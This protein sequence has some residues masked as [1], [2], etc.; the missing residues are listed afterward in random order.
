M[1]IPVLLAF[2]DWTLLFLRLVV[3]LIFLAHGWPKLKDLKATQ[4]NF[5]MMGFKPGWLWGT[6][7]A[8]LEGIGS[9]LLILGLLTQAFGLLF[10]VEMV[11]AAVWKKNRGMGLVNGYELDLLL[12]VAGLVLATMGGGRWALGF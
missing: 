3:G 5:G 9:V 7:V 6:V 11:V 8:V 12:I 10:A 2:N 4:Q 1:I